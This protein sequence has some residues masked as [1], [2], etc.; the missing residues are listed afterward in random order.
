MGKML[1]DIYC[2]GVFSTCTAPLFRESEIGVLR[3]AKPWVGAENPP[4]MLPKP[5]ADGNRITDLTF[6]ENP[7]GK[8]GVPGQR[9]VIADRNK[10]S[11]GLLQVNKLLNP[12]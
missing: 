3:T 9:V 1:P 2:M 4:P 12:F 5:C 10:A 11:G 8:T 7:G 6:V